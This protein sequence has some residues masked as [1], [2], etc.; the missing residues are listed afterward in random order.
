LASPA[1]R[2]IHEPLNNGGSGQ[3]A[4]GRSNWE[5]GFSKSRFHVG[6]QPLGCVAIAMGHFGSLWK[7]EMYLPWECTSFI[8]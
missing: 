2:T 6:G 3:W 4:V 7:E 8:E 5:S 1:V